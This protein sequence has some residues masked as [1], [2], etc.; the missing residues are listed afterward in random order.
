MESQHPFEDLILC[1]ICMNGFTE[2][3]EKKPMFLPCGHTF[4]LTCIRL[5]YKRPQIQCPVDKK[6][7]RIL[8]LSEGLQP[9]YAVIE[10]LGKHSSQKEDLQLSERKCDKHLREVL[11]FF[12]K[13]DETLICQECLIK[14]GHLTHEICSSEPYLLGDS[15]KSEST[16]CLNAV[17][18]AIEGLE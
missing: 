11:K 1:K 12:C 4:C 3:G 14:E 2:N 10:M 7:H 16:R 5:M 18:L 8:N 13:T 9:N 17:N 6:S 15:L